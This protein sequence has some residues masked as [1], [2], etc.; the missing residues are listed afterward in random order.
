V[1]RQSSG[2]NDLVQPRWWTI[3]GKLMCSIENYFWR[4][5]IIS[6]GVGNVLL[7][8]TGKGTC[9]TRVHCGKSRV[10]KDGTVGMI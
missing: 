1:Y 2:R 10:Q 3:S 8:D 5:I 4:W 9:A 6:K 7:K